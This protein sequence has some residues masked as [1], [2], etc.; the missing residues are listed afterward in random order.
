MFKTH[1]GTYDTSILSID[2][3]APD[4]IYDARVDVNGN[5]HV[6][7][8]EFYPGKRTFRARAEPDGRGGI[9]TFGKNP[10]ALSKVGAYARRV[11]DGEILEFPIRLG[12]I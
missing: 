11:S 4:L 7:R 2:T 10:G 5:E 6:I 12:L 9:A 8:Y 3:I 1:A